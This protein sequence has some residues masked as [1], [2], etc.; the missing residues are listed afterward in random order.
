MRELLFSVTKK[1]LDISYFNGTGKGGQNRNKVAACVHMKHRDSGV[2][3][4]AQ[5]ERSRDQNLKQAFES[6]VNHPKFKAWH[7]IKCAELMATKEEKAQEK[8]R[9][10]DAV[11]EAMKPDNIKL[12][13]KD[14][15]GHWVVN[16][17]EI[18]ETLMW[19][20]DK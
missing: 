15:N 8:K 14:A 17:D 13:V 5:R 19:V 18:D 9:I 16:T 12:E 4:T 2:C 1:D 10:D 7:K 20:E 11:D 3:V 6:L